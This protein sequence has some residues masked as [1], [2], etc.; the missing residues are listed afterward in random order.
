MSTKLQGKI[1]FEEKHF[2]CQQKPF[3]VFIILFDLHLI[4]G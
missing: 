4:S 3:S 2:N 1:E